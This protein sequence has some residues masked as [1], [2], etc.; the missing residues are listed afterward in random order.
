MDG[1]QERRWGR[2]KPLWNWCISWLWWKL[3]YWS[4]E[5]LRK[6]RHD[7]FK[8]SLVSSGN[9]VLLFLLTFKSPEKKCLVFVPYES[10]KASSRGSNHKEYLWLLVKLWRLKTPLMKYNVNEVDNLT[11]TLSC[12]LNYPHDPPQPSSPQRSSIKPAFQLSALLLAYS[13]SQPLS[14]VIWALS[15]HMMSAAA[16]L[17][18]SP[19]QT[20]GSC[21]PGWDLALFVSPLQLSSMSPPHPAL[22]CIFAPYPSSPHGN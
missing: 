14:N 8:F 21:F 7:W 17:T 9:N 13:P 10:S 1:N 5:V 4:S 12:V 3:V 6:R 11:A 18:L 20:K 22:L 2:R 15:V 19:L 16:W